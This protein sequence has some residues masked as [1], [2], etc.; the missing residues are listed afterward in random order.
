MSLHPLAPVT[1][2]EIAAIDTADKKLSDARMDAPRR[3]VAPYLSDGELARR[4]QRAFAINIDKATGS[5][6]YHEPSDMEPKEDRTMAN[7]SW[8]WVKEF[9]RPDRYLGQT[10]FPGPITERCDRTEFVVKTRDIPATKSYRVAL[11]HVSTIPTIHTWAFYGFFK[12]SVGEVLSQI[13]AMY[14]DCYPRMYYYTEPAASDINELRVG[15]YHIG[16]TTI[17]V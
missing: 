17:Y 4:A 11:E 15:D 13:P 1:P 3:R 16:R 2:E 14:F 9:A 6:Y 8:L 12:P 5:Y 10:M 7:Y